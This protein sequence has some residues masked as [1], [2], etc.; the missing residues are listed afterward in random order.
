MSDSTANDL[1]PIPTALLEALERNMPAL[2][3]KLD[4]SD[5][6]IWQEVGKRDFLKMLRVLHDR[7][8]EDRK[9]K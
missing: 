6:K 2:E 8:R 1:P 7:Q 4:W 9:G 5:R 3:P